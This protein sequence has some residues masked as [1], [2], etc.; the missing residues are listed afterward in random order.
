[1]RYYP[2]V[3]LAD[4]GTRGLSWRRLGVLIRHLPRDSAT[5]NETLGEFQDWSRADHL[6]ASVIDALL[7]LSWVTAGNKK[8]RK[9]DP[10]TRPGAAL[11]RR[12]S[13]P[14]PEIEHRLLE[15]RRRRERR[16]AD[17]D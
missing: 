10:V 6:T 16:H 5:R 4:V 8:A 14:G 13:L 9:P 2:G 12:T 15:Q 11:S 1:M 17:G 3:D 7:M